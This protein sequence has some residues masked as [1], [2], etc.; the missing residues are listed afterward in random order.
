MRRRRCVGVAEGEHRWHSWPS[1][2]VVGGDAGALQGGMCGV[3]VVGGEADADRAA[4]N[5]GGRDF[6]GD[7]DA[8]VTGG[9]FDPATPLGVGA[10]RSLVKP[11]VPT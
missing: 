4:G 3:G 11:S 8:V 5:V 9:E 6:E 1:E 2:D 7:D 10:S